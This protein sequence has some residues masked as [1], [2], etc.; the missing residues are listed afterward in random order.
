MSTIRDIAKQANVSVATVSRAFQ[1]NSRISPDTRDAILAIA[2]SS[3]YRPNSNKRV[4][5]SDNKLIGMIVSSAENP[6]YT[7]VIQ[8][9]EPHLR[10][11]GYHIIFA[12]SNERPDQEAEAFRLLLSMHVSSIIFTPTSVNE[13]LIAMAQKQG[14][15]VLQLYR[16]AYPNVNSIV[17]NDGYGGFIA[18]NHLLQYGHRRIL[19]ITLNTTIPPLR[20]PG[21]SRA[22]REAGM[23]VSGELILKL[24][25][26][27]NQS[28]LI[29]EKIS[30][31]K[32]TAIIAVTNAVALD[33]LRACQQL[34]LSVPSDISLV[35]YDD[36]PWMSLLGITAV[37]HPIDDIVDAINKSIDNLLHNKA[38]A[39][40]NVT[41]DPFLIT[42]NSVALP[43]DLK[44]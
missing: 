32:P 33:S 41:I 36:F 20:E 29:G 28:S 9:L 12:Y 24:P 5:K 1:E 8:S 42:R 37:S 3:N 6:F 38:T 25:F 14:I 43:K 44:Q 13:S 23:D 30:K 26:H 39:P 19:L 40:I 34:N 7:K 27:N 2:A 18:T 22:L 10:K 4:V 16:N 17:M 11:L 15:P 35:V 21:Y 31:L